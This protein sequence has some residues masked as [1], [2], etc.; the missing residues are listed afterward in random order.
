MGGKSGVQ[1]VDD[2][3]PF[4]SK[5]TVG[6]ISSKTG[7]FGILPAA[8]AGGTDIKDP[9]G[10]RQYTDIANQAQQT[11]QNQQQ[12]LE[13]AV[14]PRRKTLLTALAEQA[15]GDAPSIAE[16]QLKAAFDTSL[17][18]QLSMARSGR[19]NSGLAARNVANQAGQQQQNLAQQGAIAKLQEQRQAQNALANQI[20]SEQNYGTNILGTALGA[21]ANV[22]Q[23]QNNQRERNDKR[24]RD[25]LGGVMDI[26]KS[27]FT[28][29]FMAKGGQVQYLAEGGQVKSKGENM[30]SK[31]DFY[32][33]LKACGGKVQKKADGGTIDGQVN[34]AK[35]E[36]NGPGVKAMPTIV[37]NVSPVKLEDEKDKKGGAG[38]IS[39]IFSLFKAEGGQVDEEKVKKVSEMEDEQAKKIFK[40]KGSIALQKYLANKKRMPA[41]EPVQEKA[42]GGSIQ[43]NSEIPE[44][45]SPEEQKIYMEN[46]PEAVLNVRKN[47][48]MRQNMFNM[49]QQDYK[50]EGGKITDI[51]NLSKKNSLFNMV[52]ESR[53]RELGNQSKQEGFRAISKHYLTGTDVPYSDEYV[54]QEEKRL[55]K[56]AEGGIMMQAGGVPGEAEHM[57]DNYKNDKVPAMLSPGEVVVPRSVIADGP[58]AA[59]YFV[60][61]AANDV[62]YNAENYAQERPSFLK[63]LK[64][65]KQKERG[66]DSI[67]KI[68]RGK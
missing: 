27:I 48:Q 19:G 50:A 60:E 15:A 34:Y 38:G 16:K 5:G 43:D 8:I 7:A 52:E 49:P 67:K 64:G 54:K 36:N 66:Y 59:A 3:N 46:G 40:E 39:Q 2:A 35:E 25:L 13:D 6:K 17:K 4:N 14:N 62:N 20:A 56:K 53:N 63:A 32:R 51:L 31:K 24:N 28:G 37:G 22:T 21:Q 57:G 47:K 58:K 18:N 33:A 10:M 68:V 1:F 65:Q 12:F 42:E 61:K 23:M 26:G 9:A 41:S 55:Y 29:G 44:N 45:M 11:Y 30:K